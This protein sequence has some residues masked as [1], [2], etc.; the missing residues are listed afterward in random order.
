MHAIR[1]GGPQVRVADGR[2]GLPR[3]CDAPCTDPGMLCVPT[4]E[5]PPEG[6]SLCIYHEDDRDC[7]MGWPDK[8]VFYKDYDESP[9]CTPC[10]CS[11]P[12]GGECSAIVSVYQDTGCST[13]L[14][15]TFATSADPAACYAVSPGAAL[16]SKEVSDVSYQPGS[17]APSGGDLVGEPIALE[18]S[19]FCCRE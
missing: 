5:P 19:T 16:G 13:L 9:V 2:P 12:M 3:D 6:F 18:P 1:H 10:T 11:D 14:Q 17:C 8:H 7:P 4:A 15:A